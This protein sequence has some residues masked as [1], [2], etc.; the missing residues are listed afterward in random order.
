ML[1]RTENIKH[2]LMVEPCS[3]S[4]KDITKQLEYV[5]KDHVA[6]HALLFKQKNKNN[7]MVYSLILLLVV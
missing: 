5:T 2:T 4:R 7:L 1:N 3:I 6:T